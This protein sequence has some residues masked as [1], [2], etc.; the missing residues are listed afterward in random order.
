MATVRPIPPLPDFR[1]LHTYN[2]TG[3]FHVRLIAIDSNTC[4]V[5]DTAYL[6]IRV[7]TDRAILNFDITKLPPCQS[8]NYQF[9]NTST[10]PA[11]KPFQPGDFYLGFWG[12]YTFAGGQSTRHHYSFLC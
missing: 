10:P 4:N 9:T 8:L 6:N 11:S 2:N 3:T 12:R 1:L 7:R 5:A